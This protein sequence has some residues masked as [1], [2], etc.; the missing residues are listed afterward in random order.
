MNRLLTVALC[1]GIICGLAST[2]P[3]AD[4]TG[5]TYLGIGALYAIENF[6]DE[7]AQN[8]AREILPSY[9]MDLDDSIGGYGKVGYFLSEYVAIEALVQYLD[10][11]KSDQTGLGAGNGEDDVSIKGI[12]G[13]VNVKGYLPSDLGAFM[14]YGVIGAGVGQFEYEGTVLTRAA[15]GTIADGPNTRK[16]DYVGAF[17]RGGAGCTIMLSDVVGIEAEATYGSGLGDIEPAKII[18]VTGGLIVVL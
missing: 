11:F 16:D 3:G 17:I 5:R 18:T 12:T 10:E 7:W 4:L 15:D 8:T 6:D 13:T 14:P 1:L 9:S 2:S